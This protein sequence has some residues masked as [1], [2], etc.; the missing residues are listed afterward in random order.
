MLFDCFLLLCGKF[1]GSF[2]HMNRLQATWMWKCTNASACIQFSQFD[3]NF[4]LRFEFIAFQRH[5]DPRIFV[6]QLCFSTVGGVRVCAMHVCVFLLFRSLSLMSVF[7]FCS[8]NENV[9]TQILWNI[10]QKWVILIYNVTQETQHDDWQWERNMFYH[11]E[12]V[13][14]AAEATT[15]PSSSSTEALENY[16]TAGYGGIRTQCIF[17]T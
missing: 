3:S 2:L 11:R 1:T 6:L 8:I 9:F 14:E 15:R 4:T 10:Q 16:W 5:F 7:T 13:A 17:T 12:A